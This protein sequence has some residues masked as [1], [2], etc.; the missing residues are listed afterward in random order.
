MGH[1]R[2]FLVTIR[3]GGMDNIGILNSITNVISQHFSANIRKLEIE[4]VDGVFDGKITLYVHDVDEVKTIITNLKKIPD[5]K[6]V[7]RI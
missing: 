6:E 1:M 4:T 3:L 5:V 2:Q 7:A